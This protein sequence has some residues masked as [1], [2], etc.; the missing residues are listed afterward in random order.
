MGE[1][2]QLRRG[3][4]FQQIVQAD[5]KDNSRDGT[6]TNEARLAL[7]TPLN[8]VQ[9]TGRADILIS[10]LGD[11]VAVYEIKATDWDNISHVNVRRNLRKHESQLRK[12]V[13]TFLENEGQQVCLGIIYPKAPV[14]PGLRRY[15]ETTLQELGSPAYWYEEIKS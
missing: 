3:K 13:R 8:P 10:D 11:M 7:G 9:K 5:F 15:I 6:V 4:L 1:P 12:Y 14:R 2:N